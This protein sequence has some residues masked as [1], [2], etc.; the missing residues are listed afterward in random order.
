MIKFY[1]IFYE[2]L[3]IAF[4][5]ERIDG[6]K[7]CQRYPFTYLMPETSFVVPTPVYDKSGTKIRVD[8]RNKTIKALI[9]KV[10]EE[11]DM[12]DLSENSIQ[13]ILQNYID[14]N[15]NSKPIF[16]LISEKKVEEN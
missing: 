10:T 8:N 16:R 14:V 9:K 7:K 11:L 13:Q 12:T 6:V 5:K 3:P 15:N 4:I 2:D 1:E